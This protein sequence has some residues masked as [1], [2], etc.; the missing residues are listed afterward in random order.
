MDHSDR[1]KLLTGSA[2]A[3]FGRSSLT[4]MP[5]SVVLALVTFICYG[6]HANFST[7]SFFYLI[8]VVLQSLAGDYLSSV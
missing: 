7:V 3:R 6:L 2:W 8:V 4:A 5:A 1:R